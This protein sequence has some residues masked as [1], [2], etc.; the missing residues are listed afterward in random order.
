MH[1]HTRTHTYIHTCRLTSIAESYLRTHTWNSLRDRS[2]AELVGGRTRPKQHDEPPVAKSPRQAIMP[3]SMSMSSSHSGNVHTAH[4]QTTPSRGPPVAGALATPERSSASQRVYLDVENKTTPRASSTPRAN[5]KGASTVGSAK[6]PAVVIHADGSHG[7]NGS[8]HRP[9]TQL[10]MPNSAGVSSQAHVEETNVSNNSSPLKHIQSKQPPATTSS[11][12][13]ASPTKRGM[14]PM[15]LNG[16][17]HSPH[18]YGGSSKVPNG[19]YSPLSSP[20]KSE[21]PNTYSPRTTVISPP[22]D[23]N[24]KVHVSSS[25]TPTA[26]QTSRAIPSSGTTPRRLSWAS[27]GPDDL[28]TR[29]SHSII[30]HVFLRIPVWLD[31]AHAVMCITMV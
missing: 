7:E 13:D 5:T 15:V 21:V 3:P 14:P 25:P 16:Y 8:N 12:N 11:S 6:G 24:V 30:S 4:S 28:S 2:R 26:H 22:K 27:Q 19:H 10:F 23:P 9:K 29:V 1:T 17:S 18:M 31:H 20:T